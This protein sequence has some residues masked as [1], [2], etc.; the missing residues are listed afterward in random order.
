MK[1]IYKL[2][3]VIFL[4]QLFLLDSCS[5]DRYKLTYEG[6]VYDSL[7]GNPSSGIYLELRTCTGDNGRSQCNNREVGHATTDGN[8][9]FKIEGSGGRSDRY[10]LKCGNRIFGGSFDLKQNNL[11]S[12]DFTTIYLK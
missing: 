10:F 6:N 2:T 12:A 7:G 4:L 3:F 5:K 9:H 11:K 1:T 8:G